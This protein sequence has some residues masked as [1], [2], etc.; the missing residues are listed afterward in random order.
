[1]T[2]ATRKIAILG[3]TGSIGESTVR[4][5]LASQ[6]RIE[7]LGLSSHRRLKRLVEQAQQLT[8]EWIVATGGEAANFDWSGLPGSTRLLVGDEGISRLVRQPEI[9]IVVSAIV[10]SAGLAGT[11]NAVDAGKTVALA[12]KET[13]VMAGPL[14][15]ELAARRKSRIIPIDSEH[16]A[17][18]QALQAGRR[19]DLKRIILTASGGPFRTWT[20]EAIASATIDDALAH[21]TWNMGRKITVDS[22]TM[23]NKALEIV[24]A[25]WLFDLAPEE[26][27]VVVHPQSIVHSMVEF[28]DGSVVAQMSP[29]DMKLPIQYALTFPE[30]REGPAARFDWTASHRLEFEPPDLQ[31]FP[32]LTLGY[33]VARA[34]G[35]SGAVLN[36]ANEAAVEEFLSGQLSFAEI[37]PACRSVLEHHSFDSKPSLDDLLKV[38]RWARKEISRWV[39]T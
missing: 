27:E 14:V 22:A 35:T 15:M 26:I 34:G 9:D 17:V 4:V 2:I 25:R 6:G 24:E 28:V 31:R 20:A 3:S 19:A 8:P 37:V 33:E 29:P 12:N 21:P 11:W 1:M 16:S 30:R 36:A 38:D 23:M 7:V 13:L 5:A 18:F 32:A 10:G 39:C